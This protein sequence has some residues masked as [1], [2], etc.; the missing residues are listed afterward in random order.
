MDEQTGELRI[1]DA[2]KIDEGNITC[3]AENKAGK[4]TKSA[5]LKVKFYL[6]YYTLISRQTCVVFEKKFC[7]FH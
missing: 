7:G 1:L 4:A 6:L 3:V 5:Y 2:K